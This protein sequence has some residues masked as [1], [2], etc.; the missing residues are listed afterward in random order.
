[1][2]NKT[3]QA[4]YI[5]SNNESKIVNCL[6]SVL[7]GGKGRRMGFFDKPLLKICGKR[8][9]DR[10][11]AEMSKFSISIVCRQ[12]N[13]KKYNEI[14]KKFKAKILVD[15]ID[16]IG[17][18]GGIYTALTEGSTVIIGGDMPFVKS[19]VVEF[20]YKTGIKKNCDALIP[21]W[22]NGKKE[23]LLAY[24]SRTSIHAFEEAIQKKE[25]K[26]M[27]AVE[28]MNDVEFINIERIRRIDRKLISF[29]NINR[30]DDLKR[31]EKI[32]SLIDLEE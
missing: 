12:D 13:I 10:I 7:V 31:A 23:P 1:M 26:I 5:F 15:L 4:R 32:C 24:Y 30:L 28:R 29:F 11:L 14:A 16:G 18:M 8:I 21:E 22:E 27:R 17:P 2:V 6:V 19:E 25:F 3:Y 9:I 20:L